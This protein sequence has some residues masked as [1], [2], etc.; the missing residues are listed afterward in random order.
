[1]N[2]LFKIMV[3]SLCCINLGLQAAPSHVITFFFQQYPSLKEATIT[4][5]DNFDVFK[6]DFN[7]GIFVTY[8]GY[9]AASDY[10]GQITFP[11]KHQEPNFSLL[12]CQSPTPIFMLQNTI[13]HWEVEKDAEATF[14]SV[15][16]KQDEKTKFYFWSMEK[17]DLPK[18]NKIPLDTIIIHANPDGIEV[19]TGVTITS[20]SDQLVL[21]LLYVK[22]TIKISENALAFLQTSDFFGP[23]DRVF[24]A[25]SK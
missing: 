2:K 18:D 14:Y 11:R 23:I 9:K 24:K 21:P 20:K 16:R 8:F 19:P 15:E 25:G 17:K 4:N 5:K 13:S 22:P 12:V 1:M 6:N 10:N 7:T 3:M